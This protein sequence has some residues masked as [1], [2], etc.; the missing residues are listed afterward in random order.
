MGVLRITLK[1]LTPL[2]HSFQVEEKEV[3]LLNAIQY[4]RVWLLLATRF[5]TVI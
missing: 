4:Q 1:S 2:P 3:R 5:V